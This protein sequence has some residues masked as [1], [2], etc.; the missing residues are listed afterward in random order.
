MPRK[1]IG[2]YG[3][4]IPS[5]DFYQGFFLYEDSATNNYLAVLRQTPSP[6]SETKMPAPG[7]SDEDQGL[8]GSLCATLTEGARIHNE[9]LL[10]RAG[11]AISSLTD[12]KYFVV[13]GEIDEAKGIYSDFWR[14]PSE[15]ISPDAARVYI[16]GLP[17]VLAIEARLLKQVADQIGKKRH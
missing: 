6:L 9:Q 8:L 1:P 15:I 5:Y 17:D 16:C 4:I 14:M 13:R 10:F 12:S 3:V 7:V 2:Y 11:A